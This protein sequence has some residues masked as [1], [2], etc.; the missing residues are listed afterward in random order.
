MIE[1][2]EA[3]VITYIH[4]YHIHLI[5]GHT[6]PS[7]GPNRL[8]MGGR[9][10]EEQ[11]PA[12][13]QLPWCWSDVLRG[14]SPWTQSA[15][16]VLRNPKITYWCNHGQKVSFHDSTPSCQIKA[17]I[18]TSTL[19]VEFQMQTNEFVAPQSLTPASTVQIHH[20]IS[21][22]HRRCNGQPSTYSPT[23]PFA[24]TALL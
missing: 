2:L 12:L 7:N 11:L 19:S 23:L 22:L 8:Y 10:I 16:Y 21:V 13:G 6:C 17:G 3:I 4:A 24:D 20:T 1:P 5:S 18:G 15:D 14:L 9:L